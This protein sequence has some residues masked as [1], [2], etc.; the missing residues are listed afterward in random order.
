M[1]LRGASTVLDTVLFV[2]LVGVAV[3]V[4]AGADTGPQGGPDRLADETADVLATST[5]SVAFERSGSLRGGPAAD[6]EASVTVDRRAHGTYAELLAAAAVAD[7]TL[8]RRPLTGTGDDFEA[9]TRDATVRALPREAA[10]VEVR[11][12]WRP[13]THGRLG[14]TVV[15]GRAPPPDADVSVATLT[16]PSGFPNASRDIDPTATTYDRVA[17]AVAE[18]VVAGLFPE[19]RTRDALASEGP[20][21]AVVASRYRQTAAVLGIDPPRALADGD[22]RAANRRL[23]AALAP[24]VETDLTREFDSPEA[25]AEAV[26][27]DR[28][29]IV[30][31]TWSP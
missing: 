13:Y 10:N 29:R 23:V 19:N 21:R 1:D 3:T 15:A 7:P 20:D 6:A 30:V 16:V 4:L 2:V 31:R 5:T 18:S 17:R 11:A 8:R 14:G 9:A 25:A 28:V 26:A 27:V 24:A 12:T 22:V